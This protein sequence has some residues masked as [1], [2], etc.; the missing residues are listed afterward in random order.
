M[1]STSDHIC[2][3]I[4]WFYY[5]HQEVLE[6]LLPSSSSLPPLLLFL[7]E[8]FWGS[9]QYLSYLAISGKSLTCHLCTPLVFSPF[10]SFIEVLGRHILFHFYCSTNV[11]LSSERPISAL[12]LEGIHIYCVALNKNSSLKVRIALLVYPKFSLHLSSATLPQ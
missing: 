4:P 2:V 9:Q 5:K 3:L 11:S 6:Y 12:D 10:F 1:L 8:K 7:Y